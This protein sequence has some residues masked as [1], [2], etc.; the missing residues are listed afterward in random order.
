MINFLFT[1]VAGLVVA[2]VFAIIPAAIGMPF[3]IWKSKKINYYTVSF[4]G[5]WISGFII[6]FVS[7]ICYGLGY[8]ILHL[9]K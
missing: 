4:V 3:E 7:W 2:A 6:L 5:A 1:L 8:I 9:A